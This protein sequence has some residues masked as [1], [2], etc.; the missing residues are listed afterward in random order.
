MVKKFRVASLLRIGAVMC[1]AASMLLSSIP[2]VAQT[3]SYKYVPAPQ[4]TAEFV[5]KD[6]NTGV[7]SY[8]D[9]YVNNA[10]VSLAD[11]APNRTAKATS[12]SL[13]PFVPEDAFG[14][15]TAQNN[16]RR[17]ELDT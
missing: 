12:Q 4:D 14:S 11:D 16:E 6:M 5:S 9:L 7:V 2:I 8:F 15:D 1:L 13:A 10:K 17:G 3:D